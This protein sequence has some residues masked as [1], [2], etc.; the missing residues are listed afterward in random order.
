M[1]GLYV[2]FP[3]L[4]F[5]LPML[6]LGLVWYWRTEY[7]ALREL[8]GVVHPS[9]LHQITRWLQYRNGKVSYLYFWLYASLGSISFLSLGIA[10]ASPF[11]LGD[12][13]ILSQQQDVY[14]VLDG[15][16]SMRGSDNNNYPNEYPL[17][18]GSRFSEAKVHAMALSDQLPKHRFGVI[19]FSGEAVQHTHPHPDKEWVR[20]VLQQTNFHNIFVS[21][22]NFGELYELLLGS[23]RFQS[24]GFQVV[25]YSDG[26]MTEEEKESAKEGLVLFQRMKIPIHVVGVGS[27]E[28]TKL[29]MSYNRLETKNLDQ[30][31]KGDR[32]S[33][34]YKIKKNVIVQE[35]ESKLDV[36]FL[37]TIASETGGVYVQTSTGNSGIQ[38]IVEAI[39]K[40]QN[41]NQTLIWEA[42]GRKDQ[43]LYFFLLPLGFLILDRFLFRKGVAV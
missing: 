21:G 36:E 41:Q 18:P 28:G 3:F 38:K 7:S 14:V 35:R 25:L 22:N 40:R 31:G 32:A 1:M 6:A 37:Q 30:T 19:T 43:S 33:Q 15:S 9:R 23:S 2:Q 29:T 10:I 24:D 11:S 34:E 27:P 39:Q 42:S 12:S 5:L 8:V 17:K 20:L 4:L 13:E 16:W 26:D